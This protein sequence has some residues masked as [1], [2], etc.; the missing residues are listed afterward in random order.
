MTCTDMASYVDVTCLTDLRDRIELEYE[1][2]PEHHA[3][4][5]DARNR[6]GCKG[7]SGLRVSGG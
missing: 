2:S 6:D 7:C 3:K 1:W 4:T 5:S